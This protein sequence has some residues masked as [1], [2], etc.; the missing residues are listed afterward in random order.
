MSSKDVTKLPKLQPKSEHHSPSQSASRSQTRPPPPVS[1]PNGGGRE[2]EGKASRVASGTRGP[3]NKRLESPRDDSS[4]PTSSRQQN[5]E[6]E[7]NR[8]AGKPPSTPG[9]R[10]TEDLKSRTGSFPRKT[11]GGLSAD[12]L[13][14]PAGRSA[15]PP[16]GQLIY[17]A[18]QSARQSAGT[19]AG[20]SARPPNGPPTGPSTPSARPSTPTGSQN[21]ENRRSGSPDSYDSGVYRGHDNSLD[22]SPRSIRSKKSNSSNSS[23]ETFIKNVEGE[24]LYS[25]GS[26][27]IPY[28]F[29]I[30]I[31]G[32]S[33]DMINEDEVKNTNIARIT[34]IIHSGKH[35]ERMVIVAYQQGIGHKGNNISSWETKEQTSQHLLDGLRAFF[36]MVWPTERLIAKLVSINYAYISTSVRNRTIKAG[37]PVEPDR[38]FLFGFS[39]GAYI[40]QIVAAI[41]ADLGIFSRCLYEKAFPNEDKALHG[42]NNMLKNVVD[43]WIE[44]QGNKIAV[45]KDL[46]DYYKC[47]VKIDIEFLGHFDKVASIGEP[48]LLDKDLQSTRYRFAEEVHSR[49]RIKNAYHA[50]AISEHREQF[51]PVLWTKGPTS[52]GQVISQVWFPGYHTSIGGGTRE[53]GLMI[54]YITLVWMLSKLQGLE[55]PL[56]IERPELNRLILKDAKEARI[57]EAICKK[58]GK[59]FV[60]QDSRMALPWDIPVIMGDHFRLETD[61]CPV[62]RLHRTCDKDR[63]DLR[64]MPSMPGPNLSLVKDPLK[65]P[66]QVNNAWGYM[67]ERHKTDKSNIFEVAYL[68]YMMKLKCTDDQNSVVPPLRHGG[69]VSIIP[70]PPS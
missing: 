46:G 64:C 18:K 16:T 57:A 6:R 56:S 31:D 70:S 15:G 5:R 60:I 69:R 52:K 9:R 53:A 55:K 26:S 35:N 13:T 24:V 23:G 33:N 40:S 63:W 32:T 28:D 11:A 42:Y 29:V 22:N 27:N 38:V 65:R 50:V 51:K 12:P 19:S 54:Y 3:L 4:T 30:C 36:N 61:P 44:N 58:A 37:S 39:R 67:Y 45:K 34:E 41:V 66:K 21:Q 17:S 49:P 43:S 7:E 48:D 68:D 8:P 47:L 2:A 62:D 14:R 59:E 20:I 25:G 1:R 10:P